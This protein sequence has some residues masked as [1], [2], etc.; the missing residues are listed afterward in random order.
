[1]GMLNDVSFTIGGKVI[2]LVEHQSTI[3]ENLPIRLLLYIARVYE[4]II[5]KKAMY[6][7]K[8][9]KIPTPELIV[10][11]NGKSYYP[12][13]KVLRL[14]DAFSE[15]PMHTEMFG[16]LELTVRV[17]NL[18]GHGRT[19]LKTPPFGAFLR[20]RPRRA[21]ARRRP[22]PRKSPKFGVLRS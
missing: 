3:S 1:M 18:Q 15:A 2:F 16:G 14:S 10:L 22:L 12:D 21:S 17:L 7:Q 8:L 19:R 4:K 11:Y 20:Y 13:E 9:M 5:E 6:R